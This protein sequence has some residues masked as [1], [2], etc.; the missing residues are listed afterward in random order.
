MANCAPLTPLRS[1][2]SQMPL[3]PFALASSP[4]RSRNVWE[5]P[6]PSCFNAGSTVSAVPSTKL[7]AV[8]NPSLRNPGS[9]FGCAFVVAHKE[10]NSNACTAADPRCLLTRAPCIVPPGNFRAVTVA[11]GTHLASY[12]R[13]GST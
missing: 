2:L 1:A 12:A 3:G 11:V 10:H 9:R 13:R 4:P 5:M 6:M 8:P 7:S